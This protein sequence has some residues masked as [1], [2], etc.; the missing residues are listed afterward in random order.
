MSES[1]WA[2]PGHRVDAATARRTILVQHG[3]IRALLQ[4]AREVVDRALAA[5]LQPSDAV[6]SAIGDIHTT[7][8]VHLTYEERVLIDL[9]NDDLP[10]G[11]PRAARL[12]DEHARQRKMLADLHTEAKAGPQVPL[13]VVKLSFLTKWLLEDMEEEERTVLTEDVVRDDAV[14]IDQSC[15]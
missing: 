14:V 8:E 3:R 1:I 9:F 12:R 7:M 15:G 6:A 2:V 5:E 4:H 11:P 10:L 13:L